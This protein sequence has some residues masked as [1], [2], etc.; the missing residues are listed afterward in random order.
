MSD[1]QIMSYFT[2]D[3]LIFFLVISMALFIIIY[4]LKQFFKLFLIIVIAISLYYFFGAD[5]NIKNDISNCVKNSFEIRG[6]SQSCK[7]LFP[8]KSKK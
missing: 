5:Q 7:D 1:Q 4:L 8:E 2:M 3:N 6:I